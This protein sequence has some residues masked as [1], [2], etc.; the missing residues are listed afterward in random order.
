MAALPTYIPLDEAARRLG[1]PSAQLRLLAESGKIEAAQ[2]PDGDV[3]VDENALK[4]TGE[5]PRY[6]PIEDA[7]ERYGL[8]ANRLTQLVEKGELTAITT[9]DGDVLVDEKQIES[10]ALGKERL[11]EYQKFAHLAGNP[12]WLGK[13]SRIYAIPGPTISRWAKKGLVRILGKDG[14]KVLIDEADIA[15]CAE[16]YRQRGG[17]GKWLFNPDG[18]PYEP[19]HKKTLETA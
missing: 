18:T 3:M 4:D 2:L 16:I 17:Q 6:I 9:P 10:L 19:K 15:Y 5:L 13:A 1:I 11:P 12:I 7:V 8:E 14:Q